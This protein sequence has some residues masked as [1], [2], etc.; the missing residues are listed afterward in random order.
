MA[1]RGTFT[2]KLKK[3]KGGGIGVGT[4]MVLVVFVLFCLITFAALSYVTSRADYT[5]SEQSETTV[6]NYY[7]ACSRVEEQIA[8][9]DV[10]SL[11][12]GIVYTFN[13]PVDDVRIL[14]VI[15]ESTGDSDDPFTVKR[16]AVGSE[17]AG[18]VSFEEEG[19][20]L[21]LLF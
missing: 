20:G 1:T 5:K 15:I 4:S 3:K 11:S 6:K 2:K 14:S 12:A 16:W 7:D 18:G 13:E 10:T 17:S 21:N 9:I 8:T 19:V